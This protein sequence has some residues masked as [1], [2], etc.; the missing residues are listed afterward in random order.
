MGEETGAPGV[1]GSGAG[2]RPGAE[3]R[4]RVSL[5]KDTPS[6]STGTPA[7]PAPADSGAQSGF[8]TAAGGSGA[9]RGFGTSAGGFGAAA[10][11]FGAERGFGAAAGGFGAVDGPGDTVAAAGP[12]TPGSGHDQQTLASAPGATD[13]AQP[14]REPQ[15]QPSGTWSEPNP[16]APPA[17]PG[18]TDP[19]APP[20]GS[21]PGPFAPPAGMAPGPFAPPAPMPGA[22]PFAPPAHA[23]VGDNPFA[24]PQGEP[25]PPPP[26]APD[27]PGQVPYG[28]PGAHGPQAHGFPAGGYYGW[29]GMQALPS[30]GT[31]TAGLVL[32]IVAAVLFCMWPLAIIAGILG[33]IFGAMGRAKAKRGEAT[34]GGQALAGLICG[35]AGVVLSIAMVVVLVATH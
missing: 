25:V 4:P 5:G 6:P 31:G 21:V 14:S 23:A 19:F 27:G 29:P 22:G 9:E 12:L 10:G 28:Y 24:P 1:P 34:N 7:W 11:G 35:A 20:A 15:P 16:F 17:A 33:V 32:G 8:G 30:N 13:A 2:D 18:T 3:E 26:I